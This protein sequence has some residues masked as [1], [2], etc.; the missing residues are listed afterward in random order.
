MTN[1]KPSISEDEAKKRKD[2]FAT[3]KQISEYASIPFLRS[4]ENAEA[5]GGGVVQMVTQNALSKYGNPESQMPMEVINLAEELSQKEKAEKIAKVK[6]RRA[7]SDQEKEAEIKKIEA[8]RGVPTYEAAGK[9]IDKYLDGS[10]VDDVLKEVGA[11]SSNPKYEGKTIESLLK[12]EDKDAKTFATSLVTLYKENVVIK[13]TIEALNEVAKRGIKGSPLEEMFFKPEGEVVA[14]A[15]PDTS[16]EKVK[17]SE[18]EKEKGRKEAMAFFKNESSVLWA[19]S[20][21]VRNDDTFGPKIAKEVSRRARED[22]IG[23]TMP[24]QA[25][26]EGLDASSGRYYLEKS[27]DGCAGLFQ[28]YL[29]RLKVEDVV[30]MAGWKNDNPLYNNMYLSE[31][32]TSKDKAE[33]EF[34]TALMGTYMS[35]VTSKRVS[36]VMSKYVK[37]SPKML[38]KY[39]KAPEEKSNVVDMKKY[40]EAKSNKPEVKKA[41]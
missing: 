22:T 27:E 31:L 40:K 41:A 7:I 6:K 14:K 13:Q 16:D 30:K 19:L 17:K 29:A 21:L 38:D 24:G 15:R 18:E 25:F 23:K 8:E 28:N 11:K 2:S 9:I 26:L 33:Q 5:F 37:E 4:K 12:G 3:A 32:Y 34:A 35:Q 10:S 36:E 1:K 39:L 20:G